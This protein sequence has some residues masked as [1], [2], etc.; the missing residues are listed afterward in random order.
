MRDADNFSKNI[1]WFR[2]KMEK[3]DDY[4]SMHLPR[5]FANKADDLFGNLLFPSGREEDE[6][7]EQSEK[8]KELEESGR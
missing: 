4:V 1:D 3:R 2:E 8:L 6:A 7:S 5:I